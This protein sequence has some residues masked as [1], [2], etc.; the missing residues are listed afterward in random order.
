MSYTLTLQCGCSIF[1]MSHPQS[2]IAH[3][4]ILERRGRF[5][6]HRG[7]QAGMRLWLWDMLPD[8]GHRDYTDISFREVAPTTCKRRQGLS[9]DR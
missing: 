4:R 6:S 7:H 8:Q 2:G 5:C 1:V 9:D 3:S